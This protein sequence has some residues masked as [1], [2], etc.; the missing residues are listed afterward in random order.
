MN[1]HIFTGI[2]VMVSLGSTAA[3]AQVVSNSGLVLNTNQSLLGL[4]VGN[5][6]DQSHAL[7]TVQ[8]SGKPAIGVGALSGNPSHFGSALSVSALNTSRL[9]GVDSSGGP[10]GT[11]SLSLANPRQAPVLSGLAH[12]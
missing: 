11:G 8:P 7:V 1:K 3:G 6:I 12:R 10:S 9:L 5:G 2:A 4:S